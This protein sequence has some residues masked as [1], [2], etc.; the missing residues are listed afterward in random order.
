MKAILDVVDQVRK[1]EMKLE[2]LTTTT[3]DEGLA[4]ILDECVDELH[5]CIEVIQYEINNEKSAGTDGPGFDD[6]PFD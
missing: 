6:T 3:K 2:Y 4:F 5:G 1:V